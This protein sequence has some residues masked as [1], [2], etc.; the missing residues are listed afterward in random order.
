M[1]VA[2]IKSFCVRGEHAILGQPIMFE[3]PNRRAS[4]KNWKLG[5]WFKCLGIK[6]NVCERSCLSCMINA[7][8]RLLSNWNVKIGPSSTL[9][10]LLLGISKVWTTAVKDGNIVQEKQDRLCPGT[11]Y[12]KPRKLLGQTTLRVARKNSVDGCAG[13]APSAMAKGM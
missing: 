7:W 9:N 3:I 4:I 2:Y 8:K 6:Y 12:K 1:K 10:S 11:R 5:A 13:R